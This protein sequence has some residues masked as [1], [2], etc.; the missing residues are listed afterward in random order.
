[1]L[2]IISVQ[3][4]NEVKKRNTIK[5]GDTFYDWTII[6]EV[7]SEEK[8]KHYLVTCKCGFQ[9]II[10]GIRLRFGDSKQCRSCASTRHGMV[11]SKTYSIWECIIQRTTNPNHTKYQYYGGRGITI[12]EEWRDFKNFLKD[13]GERP[14]GYEI[15]RIDN[16]K[17]Y[18]KN[19]C[20]WTTR[21]ENLKN[22]RASRLKNIKQT[23]H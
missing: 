7:P 2:S 4:N 22:R 18:A 21:S 1:M 5:P 15:D 13:M 8:R 17:G 16:N 23:N 9:K 20:R 6:K 19:N 10:K 12:C 3:G 11:H 14:N